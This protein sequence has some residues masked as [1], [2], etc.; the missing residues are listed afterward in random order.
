MKR[1]AERSRYPEDPA[2]AVPSGRPDIVGTMGDLSRNGSTDAVAT[3]R[4]LLA[5]V[6]LAAADRDERVDE[7]PPRRSELVLSDVGLSP[8][9][10]AALTGKSFDTVRGTIRRAAA[11]SKPKSKAG[12]K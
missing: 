2:V 5:M 7:L 4:I 9:E 11:R 12:Q 3:E 1:V 6:A 8:S 10:I